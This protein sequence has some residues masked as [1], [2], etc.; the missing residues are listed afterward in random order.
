MVCRD[1]GKVGKERKGKERERN[2]KLE[3]RVSYCHRKELPQ[4]M[5][6][7]VTLASGGQM[8]FRA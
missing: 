2:S 1:K 4:E 6:I 5:D 7:R 3:E 8:K